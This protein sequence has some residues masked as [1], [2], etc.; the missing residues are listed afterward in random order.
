MKHFGFYVKVQYWDTLPTIIKK[1]NI[2]YNKIYVK[3]LC[4]LFYAM[5]LLDINLIILIVFFIF[6]LLFIFKSF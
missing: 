5:M 6:P 4:V 2:L 3:T 1:S